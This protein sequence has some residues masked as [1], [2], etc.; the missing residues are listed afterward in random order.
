MLYITISFYLYIPIFDINY[1]KVS[2]CIWIIISNEYEYEC[3]N[4]NRLV[5]HIHIM[6]QSK[7]DH[8]MCL[9]SGGLLVA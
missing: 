8:P 5:K 3:K 7:H 9:C 2:I 6:Y 1:V 4:T